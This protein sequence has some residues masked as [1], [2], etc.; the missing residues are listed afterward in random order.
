MKVVLSGLVALACLAS[1]NTTQ[2][3][4]SQ[5]LTPSYS[6]QIRGSGVNPGW[7]PDWGD[8]NDMTRNGNAFG[9]AVGNSSI[10]GDNNGAVETPA[11]TYF[12]YNNSDLSSPW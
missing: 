2:A 10:D 12:Y 11:R 6:I 7:N 4:I 8:Y 3:A 5:D 1:V 9:A